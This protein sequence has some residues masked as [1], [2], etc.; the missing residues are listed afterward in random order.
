MQNIAKYV[1]EYIL[2]IWFIRW[3]EKN[4]FPIWMLKIKSFYINISRFLKI[5]DNIIC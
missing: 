5:S 4:I 2:S 3:A 1:Y